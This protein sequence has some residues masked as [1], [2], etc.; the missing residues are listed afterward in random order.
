MFI[1]II[2]KFVIVQHRPAESISTLLKLKAA[3]IQIG[4]SLPQEVF[5]QDMLS[6]DDLMGDAEID[7]QPMIE[8]SFAFG[9]PDLLSDMQI[10]KWLK[11]EDNSLI[12]NSI[13]NI[14]DGKI[15]QELS[16][17]LR[18]VESGEIYL[19]IEWIPLMQ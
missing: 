13:V 18:N 4:L 16:I 12:D 3:L 7:L 6:A 5:D 15:I 14:V 11:S 17:R 10:G 19:S 8:S 1:I 9:D 2:F